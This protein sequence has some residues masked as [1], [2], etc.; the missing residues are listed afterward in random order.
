MGRKLILDDHRAAYIE[1][2][3]PLWFVLVYTEHESNMDIVIVPGKSED[4]VRKLME[5]KGQLLRV[6][7]LWSLLDR[8]RIIAGVMNE[9]NSI[10]KE[11]HGQ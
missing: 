11:Q 6:V 7:Q 3:E 2:G 9:I 5:G 1:Q 10:G 4:E 8:A